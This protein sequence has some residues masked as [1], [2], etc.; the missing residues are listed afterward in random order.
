MQPI[1]TLNHV[2]SPDGLDKI[3]ALAP[4]LIISFRYGVILKETL[5]KNSAAGDRVLKQPQLLG[6][7]F[8]QIKLD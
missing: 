1:E 5:I 4:D 6:V 7:L 2:N 3:Q 8:F